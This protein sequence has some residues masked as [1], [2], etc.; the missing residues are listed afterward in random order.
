M[1]AQ[2]SPGIGGEPTQPTGEVRCW[3]FDVRC[4][5]MVP[6]A[7][8]EQRTPNF[9]QPVARRAYP[10]GFR[11]FGLPP[12]PDSLR[13][14][15]LRTHPRPHCAGPN[16][17]TTITLHCDGGS[18]RHLSYLAPSGQELAPSRCV[19]ETRRRLPGFNG[20]ITLHRSGYE[21]R[22][23]VR[24]KHSSGNP[25]ASSDRQ[26][27]NGRP[28]RVSDRVESHF[29]DSTRRMEPRLNPPPAHL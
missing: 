16:A 10:A 21:P 9:F 17:T 2:P 28:M 8:S 1:H 13:A 14:F 5:G 24:V 4:R 22:S 29:I 20:P 15:P 25:S 19:L 27:G 23:L 3:K 6:T 7:N 12:C 18:L 11:L 26:D